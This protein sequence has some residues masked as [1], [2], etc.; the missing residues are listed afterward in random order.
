MSVGN[1]PV[2]FSCTEINVF[3]RFNP[4]HAHHIKALKTLSFRRL[5]L[6]PHH[7]SITVS[8][9]NINIGHRLSLGPLKI[10]PVRLL[11]DL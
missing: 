3:N 8:V 4:C 2:A 6:C 10:L 7:Y 9:Q 5:F 1:D 11:H